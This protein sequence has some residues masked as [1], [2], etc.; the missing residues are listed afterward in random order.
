MYDAQLPS[1]APLCRCP[2]SWTP[3]PAPLSTEICT[4]RLRR[5][6]KCSFATSFLYLLAAALGP[7]AEFAP[8][9]HAADKFL[10]APLLLPG[11]HALTGHEAGRAGYF[12]HTTIIT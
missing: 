2:A 5:A 11:L 12:S 1:A 6:C 8:F 9:P 7:T 4:S 10:L 3:V